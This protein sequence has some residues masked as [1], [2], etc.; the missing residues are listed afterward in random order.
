[1]SASAGQLLEL[2]LQVLRSLVRGMLTATDD[3]NEYYQRMQV[4]G[5]GGEVHPDVQ[6]VQPYGLYSNP[7]DGAQVL[8]F[9]VGGARDHLIGATVSD[10]RYRPKNRPKGETGLHG[11]GYTAVRC[12]PDG[13]VEIEGGDGSVH[14]T[15]DPAGNIVIDGGTVD[16]T[17]TTVAI[18]DLTTIDGKPFLTHTHGG[19]TTGPGSTGPV[20]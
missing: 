15:V 1:M 5:L 19:V 20:V 12:R 17:G 16:I 9:E 10:E 6:H 3:S 7:E 2:S 8:L 18:G 11:K 4:R 14:I 13:T